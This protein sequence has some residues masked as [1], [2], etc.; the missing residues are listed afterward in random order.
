VKAIELKRKPVE[1]LIRGLCGFLALFTLFMLTLSLIFSFGGDA[2]SLFGRNVYIIKTDAIDFLKPGTALFT[3]AVPYNEI[4]Q[5]N[6]VVFKSLETGRAGVAE[7][8]SV[9]QADG[10]YKYNAISERG[11]ELVLT[12]GQIVGRATQQSNFLGALFGFAK[13]PAG[14][15]VI[16]VI[17]CMVILIYESSKSIFTVFRKEGRITPVKKQDEVPTYVPRQKSRLPAYLTPE[18]SDGRSDDYEKVLDNILAKDDGFAKED[19]PL[20]SPPGNK[21]VNPEPPAVK[22]P[23]TRTAPRTAP[24]SQK[25]LNQA[26]AE[27]NA[28]NKP[29]GLIFDTGEVVNS[30][31]DKGDDSALRHALRQ[32]PADVENSATSELNQLKELK[33]GGNPAE[34]VKQYNPKKGANQRNTQTASTPSLDKLLR[35][36]DSETE[37]AGYN[38]E[39]ILFSIDKRK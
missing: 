9:E 38:I 33:T 28:R 3:Q 24:L 1:L 17:P 4:Y 36:D 39:D 2:P 10:V 15:L 26:I 22:K 34:K 21:P 37:N 14:V 35:E 31:P 8:E 11:V 29:D 27:V 20:Y 12:Q 25:R 32:A 5:G 13:S 23:A 7:I 16:A 30:V 19:Y 6:I 18:A